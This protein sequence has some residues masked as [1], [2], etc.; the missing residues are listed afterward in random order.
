MKFP[1][2]YKYHAKI[3][4]E[5]FEENNKSYD[6]VKITRFSINGEQEKNIF[7]RKRKKY[8]RRHFLSIFNVNSSYW[9]KFYDFPDNAKI[10]IEIKCE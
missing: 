9:D 5:N 8:E 4:E 7:I 1:K 2:Y 6:K 3:I 10:E